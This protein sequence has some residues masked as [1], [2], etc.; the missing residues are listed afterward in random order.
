[1]ADQTFLGRISPLAPLV[2]QTAKAY[3]LNPDLVAAIVWQ[4]SAGDTYAVRF[5]PKSS[6][7]YTP[8]VFAKKLNISF[9]TETCLQHMSFGLGQVMGFKARELGFDGPLFQIC[10]FP[11]TGLDLLCKAL[12]GFKKR[13]VYEEDFIAA[14]NAGSP[15]FGKD[16]KLINHEYV[17][18]VKFKWAK[19]AKV[20]LFV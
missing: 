17:E 19:V 9:E 2:K 16:G 12:S 18:G 7:V 11:E 15:I 3:G 1:M 13:F 10:Q 14:Y 5:E 20:S 6:I 4:E 8:S